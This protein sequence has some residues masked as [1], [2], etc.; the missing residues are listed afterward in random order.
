MEELRRWA[1]S[2]CSNERP[3]LR[4][5]GKAILLLLDD[6]ALARRQALE[7]HL[8]TIAERIGSSRKT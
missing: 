7:E 2:I 6:L 8:M 1:I 4:A 3:E 5:A